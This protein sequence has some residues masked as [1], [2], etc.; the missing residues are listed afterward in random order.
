MSVSSV[1]HAAIKEVG[2]KEGQGNDNKFAA[3]A[4]HANHQPW[5]A[6]FV[7]AIFKEAGESKAIP[8][9]EIGRAHV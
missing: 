7:Y 8:N 9:T 6:T 3:M 1:I 4:G 2:Y 5:C